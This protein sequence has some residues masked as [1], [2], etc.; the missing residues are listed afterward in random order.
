MSTRHNLISYFTI[1]SVLSLSLSLSLCLSVLTQ[2]TLTKHRVFFQETYR[3]G[4]RRGSGLRERS[5]EVPAHSA[6]GFLQW[7]VWEG[8]PGNEIFNFHPK[9]FHSRGEPDVHSWW[10]HD[11]SWHAASSPSRVCM[12]TTC[13]CAWGT[14]TCRACARPWT[15][16]R[17]RTGWTTWSCTGRT[18]PWWD[19]CPSCP[20]HS[21]SCL[22]TRT[23]PASA[24]P[25]ASTRYASATC[26]WW[27]G[28]WRN[29]AN[30]I[31]W[32]IETNI[33]H[34][35]RCLVSTITAE[36]IVS[37]RPPPGCSAA[38]TRCPPC[39]PTSQHASEPGS[40]TSACP[41]TFSHFSSTSSVPNY[42]RYEKPC[43]VNVCGCV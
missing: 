5:S 40:A 15:G 8:L 31:D 41:S 3:R 7:R 13:R 30:Y 2:Y 9:A 6:L 1:L 19:T 26:A 27:W 18:S 25:T 32:Q 24:I 35:I 12:K 21:T 38:G 33:K 20:S 17:S 39:W 11:V 42:G 14:P 10:H 43:S 4:L 36:V 22:P 34:D 16:W 23:C 28:W 29:T 37:S